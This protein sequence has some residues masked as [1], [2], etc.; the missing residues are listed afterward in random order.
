MRRLQ[1]TAA[2]AM[3]FALSM[4]ALHAQQSSSPEA[5]QSITSTPILPQLPV[6]LPDPEAKPKTPSQNHP[7]PSTGHA[8]S[9]V[10]AARSETDQNSPASSIFP[11]TVPAGRPVI[12]LAL[13]GGGALGIAHIGV[14]RWFEE[15]H[16]PVDRLAGTSMGSLVGGLYASGISPEAMLKTASGTKFEDVFQ[17]EAPYS[18]LDYRSRENRRELPQGVKFG[19][20]GGLNLRNA[21]LTDNGLNNF[22]TA[23][24]IAYEDN[25]QDYNQ[26]AIPFRCVATDLNEQRPVV[27]RGGPLNQSIRASISIPAIFSPVQY[28]GHYLIDGAIVDNLPTD[29]ARNDLHSDVVIAIHLLDTPFTEGD[30][31]SIIGVM[32]SAFSA[33]TARNVR[34]S[35]EQADI[36]VV[37]DTGKFT[38]TD[39][40]KGA[41]LEQVGYA[42]AEKQKASLLKYALNDHDWAAYLAARQARIRP[43]PGLLQAVKIEGGLPEARAELQQDIAP[44]KNKPIDAQKIVTA[45][46]NVQGSG[47]YTTGIQ[48]FNPAQPAKPTSQGPSIDKGPS[49]DQV[50]NQVPSGVQAAA[51]DTGVLIRLNKVRGGPPFLILGAEVTAQTSN[52]TR[53]T[54]DVRLLNDNLGGYG[55]E[56]RTDLRLGYFTQISSEYYRLLSPRGYF[57]QPNLGLIRKPVYLWNNQRRISE[58]LEQ[59]FGGGLEIGRTFDRYMQLAAE[60]RAQD[61]RWT[62]REGLDADTNLSGTS[63]TADVRFTYDS[64]DSETL[65]PSGFRVNLTAGA[66]FQTFASQNAPLLQLHANRSFALSDKNILG[67]LVEGNSYFRRNVADPLRF[68]LGGPLHLSASSM[69]EYRGTD[70][71]LV[72]AA[73]LRR[74]AALP[75]GLGQ[76]LYIATGY[77]GGEIWSPERSAILRQDG[78]LSLG[79]ATPL[80]ML[81]FGTSIGDAGRRKIFFSLG[82]LF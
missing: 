77:E 25:D 22:L 69:D 5:A 16:I 50:S 73:Y 4:S 19:L 62:L 70:D 54:F 30:V 8:S 64:T 38:V 55:S 79:A 17:L 51:P 18:K 1:K 11:P 68:T 14:I 10:D 9:S 76:G 82:R 21:L 13:E 56:L 41:Q 72:R 49:T 63:Q 27:F 58:R 20:E 46:G 36:V 42:A 67:V 57:F 24:F 12:G 43:A 35:L 2:V 15:H 48:T 60:W 7:H 3:S 80:G 44:L 26:M 32:S 53:T 23:T 61:V 74:L 34:L 65:S 29:V 66:L 6:P 39:Y 31:N 45:L 75:S 28:H 59:Q 37:A 71:Y 33:G 40:T 81:T 52:V 47:L 78:F